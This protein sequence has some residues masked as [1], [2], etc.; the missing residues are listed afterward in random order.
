MNTHSIGI[1]TGGNGDGYLVEGLRKGN[2]EAVEELFDRFHDRI[3]HLAISILKDH[4]D[5]EEVTQDVFLTAFRKA[6]TFQGNSSLYSWLYRIGVNA[7]LMRLRGRRRA[8]TVSIEEFLP[9][10]TGEGMHAGPVHDWSRGV[11]RKVLNRE[12]GQ[13]LRK[14]IDELPDKFRVVH[15]LCDI[16]GMSN[17][18]AA[19]VLNLSVA[20]VKSRLHRARLVLRE[21]LTPY[22]RDGAT[23]RPVRRLRP[24]RP[25]APSGTGAIPEGAGHWW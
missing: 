21:R 8:D 2:P 17:E 20:A 13:L 5:A 4:G 18:E 15:V 6:D 14:Y 24:R 9:V 23:G 7:S 3:F 22:L 10:F 12:L 11:E 16:E 25:A 1:R 19:T